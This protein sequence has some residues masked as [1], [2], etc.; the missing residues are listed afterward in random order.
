[1]EVV[2][3]IAATVGSAFVLFVARA[4]WQI[5]RVAERVGESV[6]PWFEEPKPG[7]DH[8]PLPTQVRRTAEALEAVE[9][10]VG[11]NEVRLTK[12]AGWGPRA[13]ES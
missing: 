6:L 3:A 10:R 13:A 4:T 7:E 2:A 1:M 5:M 11:A 9:R 12:I 8:E